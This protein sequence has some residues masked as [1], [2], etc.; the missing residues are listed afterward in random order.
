MHYGFVVP[1]V[2]DGHSA[3]DDIRLDHLLLPRLSE[4]TRA[5]LA[6]VGYLGGYSLLPA[7]NELCFKT[8]VAVRAELLTCNEWEFFVGMGEDMTVDHTGE[9]ER[10]VRGILSEYRDE[11]VEWIRESR[12]LEIEVQRNLLVLRWQQIVDAIDRFCKPPC[13]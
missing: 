10:F 5:Q 3:D 7:A 4:Q 11:A 8:Q 13:S 9:V 12:K 2:P 1:H 6:D